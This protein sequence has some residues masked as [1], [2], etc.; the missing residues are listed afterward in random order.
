ML[1]KLEDFFQVVKYSDVKIDK[2]NIVKSMMDVKNDC[3]VQTFEIIHTQ[4]FVVQFN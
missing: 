4:E 3:K 2:F 1:F